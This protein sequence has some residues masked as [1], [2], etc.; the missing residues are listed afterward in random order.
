MREKHVAT[1]FARSPTGVTA[2]SRHHRCELRMGRASDLLRAF[3]QTHG[4]VRHLAFA[5][6]RRG[7]A[8]RR[9][10]AIRPGID[11]ER[12]KSLGGVEA[13]S[14]TAS[15]VTCSCSGVSPWPT[16]SRSG[17][18]ISRSWRPRRGAWP[19]SSRMRSSWPCAATDLGFRYPVCTR[20]SRPVRPRDASMAASQGP[21]QPGWDRGHSA[22][23]LQI[24]PARIGG[25]LESP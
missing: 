13:G 25:F 7:D 14:W 10:A 9:G 6:V 1:R 15:S 20:S 24:V 23:G 11:V 21:L 12:V 16:R 17:T 22:G 8:S 2:S 19:V 18:A 4:S 5:A 3:L